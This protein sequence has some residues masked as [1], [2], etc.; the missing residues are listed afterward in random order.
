MT[1]CEL[2]IITYEE[3]QTRP[4]NLSSVSSETEAAVLSF[5]VQQSVLY[6]FR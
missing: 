5:E 3:F 1:V 6:C 2:Q 4:M